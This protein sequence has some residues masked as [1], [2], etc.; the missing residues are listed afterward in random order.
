M[1]APVITLMEEALTARNLPKVQKIRTERLKRI[2]YTVKTKGLVDYA[3]DGLNFVAKPMYNSVLKPIGEGVKDFGE[4][5][6][7]Q[8]KDWGEVVVSETT[9]LMSEGLEWAV[10]NV[11]APTFNVVGT[12]LEATGA[13]AVLEVIPIKRI[14][15]TVAGAIRQGLEITGLDGVVSV[16]IR[17]FNEA[18]KFMAD[19]LDK[20]GLDY[21]AMLLNLMDFGLITDL[22]KFSSRLSSIYS[23]DVGAAAMG[24]IIG[25][26]LNV[27]AKAFNFEE[28]LEVT[29]SIHY[30]LSS[31]VDFAKNELDFASSIP[32]LNNASAMKIA[33]SQF[34]RFVDAPYVKMFENALYSLLESLAGSTDQEW[35]AFD[36]SLADLAPSA[37]DFSS[38]PTSNMGS[39][40]QPLELFE[41]VLSVYP[42]IRQLLTD[43]GDVA[44]KLFQRLG[45]GIRLT[46][47][48][49]SSTLPGKLLTTFGILSAEDLR[50][51]PADIE[52]WQDGIV[53]AVVTTLGDD[54]AFMLDQLTAIK[55]GIEGWS[56][57]F[58]PSL[59]RMLESRVLSA[60]NQRRSGASDFFDD[61][62]E[63]IP[64]IPLPIKNRLLYYMHA[65]LKLKETVLMY[66]IVKEESQ[67]S[68]P[69]FQRIALAK[70]R[71][72]AWAHSYKFYVLMAGK[73]SDV[74]L[75]FYLNWVIQAVV[76]YYK[77]QLVVDIRNADRD[78]WAIHPDPG[79]SGPTPGQQDFEA[80]RRFKAGLKYLLC[81]IPQV[82]LNA[83]VQI[84]LKIVEDQGEPGEQY[85]YSVRKI[86]TTYNDG[87][88]DIGIASLVLS[89]S[90]NPYLIA[91]VNAMAAASCGMYLE[92]A[93]DSWHIN[94]IHNGEP[95]EQNR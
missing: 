93:I 14:V 92:W 15:G 40:T 53:L 88:T 23:S 31:A 44:E 61:V 22:F 27:A 45:E 37:A 2:S 67:Q 54:R 39:I 85:Q 28:A 63:E 50:F 87:L 89:N 58:L 32:L 95:K 47:L 78:R 7:N 46:V 17:T 49:V 76:L 29:D 52:A 8:A 79:N 6:Y 36:S 57:D 19:V 16:V 71:G 73:F 80:Q 21:L 60:G 84:Y 1:D 62:T 5:A 90:N 38:I 18:R 72:E 70:D 12:V 10:E 74:P 30:G 66:K 25:A 9:S 42:K 65:A 51:T 83:V 20:L 69:M 26:G 48:D 34:S 82:F 64:V 33:R 77:H 13:L 41:R 68:S 35:D 11:V 4:G 43:P 24:K 86:V 59:L 75:I 81:G 91:L 3:G 55:D 94:S 56:N